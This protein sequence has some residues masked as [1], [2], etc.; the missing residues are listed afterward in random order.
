MILAA[1]IVLNHCQFKVQLKLNCVFVLFC[2]IQHTCL[3]C[4]LLVSNQKGEIHILY[5]LVL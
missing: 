5:F 1:V 3:L 4:K 2:L